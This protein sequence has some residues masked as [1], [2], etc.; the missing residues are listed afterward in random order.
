VRT[1]EARTVPA[2]FV[3]N[4]LLDGPV[5]AGGDLPGSLRQAVF[6]ANAL[7]GPDVIDLT[8]VPGTIVLAAGELGVTDAVA[9]QGPGAAKLTLDGAGLSRLFNISDGKAASIAVSLS[10]LT[11]TGGSVADDDGGAILCA[12]ESLTL[13]GMVVAGNKLTGFFGRGGG[14]AMAADFQGGSLTVT[15]STIADNDAAI[16]QGGGIF[17]NFP[18]SAGNQL[19]LTNSTISGNIAGRR[20]GGIYFSAGTYAASSFSMRNCTVS[21]NVAYDEFGGGIMISGTTGA[22]LSIAN[23]TITGNRTLTNPGGGGLALNYGTGT[24]S[25]ESTIIS[26]NSGPSPA[27]DLYSNSNTTINSK[28]NLLG[29]IGGVINAG[30]NFVD[31]GGTI[32]GAAKLAPLANNG[33]PTRTHLLTAVSPAIDAGSNPAPALTTDQR[34]AGFARQIG[35]AVDIGAVEYNP[36]LPAALATTTN[37]TAAGGTTYTFTV[38]YTDDVGINVSTIGNGD[39][40]VTG[41]NGFDAAATFISIDS[42][43]NGTPRVATYSITTP[44]GA[45]DFSD[46]GTYSI[47][48]QPNQV[49]DV[50]GTAI[51]TDVVGTFAVAIARSLV[52]TSAADSG[53]GSLRE[54]IELANQNAFVADTITFDTVA[55]GTNLIQLTSNT[56]LLVTDAVTISA[57]SPVTIDG[58][59]QSRIMTVDGPGSIAVTLSGLI[60]VNGFVED[61]PGGAVAFANEALTLVNCTFVNN[62]TGDGNTIQGGAG[63]AVGGFGFFTGSLLVDGCTFDGN[64]TGAGSPFN[65]GGAISTGGFVSNYDVVIRN[66]T[67]VNNKSLINSGGALSFNGGSLLVENSTFS[68]NTAGTGGGAIAGGGYMNAGGMTIRNTTIS[69]NKSFSSGGGLFLSFLS[70]DANLVNCTVVDNV[71]ADPNGQFAGGGI[72]WEG[73]FGGV[74]NLTNTVVAR[75]VSIKAA[76]IFSSQSV[77]ANTSFIGIANGLTLV[78]SGNITG[79]TFSP[80][81]PFLAPLANNGGPTATH[82]PYSG[83]PL[84]DAGPATS[85]LTNDQ[86]GAGFPRVRNGK[87]DIG[88]VEVDPNIPSAVTSLAK[89]TTAG[90]TVYTFT[91]TYADD[92]AINVSTLDNNDVRVTGPNGFDVFATFK[93]VTPGGNGTPRVATYEFTPPGG[94]WDG[95]D[96]GFYNVA[97]DTNQVADTSGNFVQ[98]HVIGTF[99]CGIPLNL[100]VTNANDTGPGSLRAAIEFANS[101]INVT[102]T[103][104]FDPGFFATPR[105]ITLT[106]GELLVADQVIIANATGAANVTLMGVNSRIMTVDGPFTGAAVTISGLTLTKGTGQGTGQFSAAV[107]GGAILNQ[108]EA[109][110][111]TDCVFTGNSALDNSNY[112]L[113]AGG[114]IYLAS[115]LGSLTIVDSTLTGNVSQFGGGAIAAFYDSSITITRCTISGNATVGN[116]GSG[117]GVLLNNG[118]SLVI[119]SSSIV[120]NRA[121]AT[122]TSGGGGVSVGG[123]GTGT[124]TNST[125][126][127]NVADGSGG[128]VNNSFGFDLTIR[129]S[130]ITGNAA[131]YLGGGIAGVGYYG[132]VTL[133][134]TIV[135]GNRNVVTPDLATTNPAFTITANNSLIGAAD[136]AP[137]TGAANKTGTKAAPLDPLLGPLTTNGGPTLSFAPRPGSPAIDAGTNPAGLTFDQR[138][139][140]F[141]RVLG[142]AADIGA[143]EVNPVLPVATGSFA[144]VVAA[145]GTNYTLKINFSDDTAINVATLGTGDVRVTGPGGFNVIPLFVSVDVNTNGTPRVATYSFVAPGGAWDVNDVGNYTVSIEPNQ[146]ADVGGN[147]VAAAA[148]NALRVA[149]P[150]TLVVTNDLDAGPGS[151][152][153]AIEQANAAVGVSDVITFDPA[154]FNTPRTITLNGGQLVINDP[155]TITGP[156]A[157]LVTVDAA[158]L[159]R[160]LSIDLGAAEWGQ[161]V[162]LSGLTLANGYTGDGQGAGI[163]NESAALVLDSCVVSGCTNDF[164]SGGAIVLNSIYSPLT[165]INTTITENSAFQGAGIYVFGGIPSIPESLLVTIQNSTISKN[166]T[167]FGGGAGIFIEA[168]GAV[169]IQNSTLAENVA[170]G[171]G[172]GVYVNAGGRLTVEGSTFTGNASKSLFQGGGAL[173]F[174]GDAVGSITNSTISG[175]TA[176]ESAG[177]ILAFYFDGTLDI[178]NTTIAFNTAVSTGGGITFF[179]GSGQLSLASTIVAKNTANVAPDLESGSP[180]QAFTVNNSL[181]GATDGAT[182]TGSNNI[183]GTIVSP[184]DPLLD[185]TLANNGGPTQT[186]KLLVGSPAINTGSNPAGLLFDQRGTGFARVS[187]GGVDMGAFEIQS[188]ASP[189][190]VTSVV[191]N[192]GGAQRSMVTSLKVTFSEAVTFPN[193]IAAAFQLERV[194]QPSGGPSAGAPLGLVNISAVQ[195]GNTV[196]ITFLGG[197]AVPIDLAGSLIDGAYRLTIVAANV[198][199]AG[200]ALDGNGNGIGGDDF[201]TPAAGAGRLFRLF[202]DNDGD[203]DVDAQD[204]GAFRA[205]FGGGSNL[206]FDFDG[207]GDVDAADF[208]QFRARFGSGV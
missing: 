193:G 85:P 183:T 112:T 147:F 170:D 195:A 143:V 58:L 77:T 34:G 8:G 16:G 66:S 204:F 59:V 104:S 13:D 201:Q 107:S 207:D 48:L 115:G 134:S 203:A 87:V 161:T 35:A 24:I 49:T 98:G 148:V 133:V 70:V 67:F 23:S 169:V 136:T 26:D 131:R 188:A 52:V 42:P 9:I 102:D 6:D 92:V 19:T 28:N 138:G 88:A 86:R 96:V 121:T 75:N 7:A 205:A 54:A 33:G 117:G 10:G 177:G 154:F 174:T 36:A 60:F 109:L 123:F 155:V 151:L 64:Q 43:T 159:Y 32:I 29:G 122:G 200:G 172:G 125:I 165:L 191:V 111:V 12:N 179:G 113:P 142:A 1:L 132:S 114:A 56:E 185:A 196:T 4:N 3:V 145:G 30:T 78:G 40:R 39:I 93:G 57:G 164:F 47:L 103:I 156:G 95:A 82:L 192:T 51:A 68:N 139:T 135:A 144:P 97:V 73:V 83:S 176:D 21:G 171:N 153:D 20:G 120:G 187:G 118:G 128:G 140:G 22:A 126:A 160:I 2:T 168:G 150:R 106:S 72:A 80:A 14:I 74:L 116:G 146:V 129:N 53:P 180:T 110:T 46:N 41:P 206:A 194:G 158:G 202:G 18:S 162:K 141:A 45:W 62:A 186:H 50:G 37:I 11:L 79:T 184:A 99:Q 27:A 100:V 17:F 71:N 137:I 175:N 149:I 81:N 157:G 105:T 25:I 94:A 90:G 101:N 167:A 69:G 198:Q 119:D 178:R 108:D 152:R 91:V 31:Q 163:V 197:G 38:T 208:G 61:G 63:G 89:V 44:G 15:N 76:D 130:T 65:R 5:N 173:F 199:G 55:M 84:V 182:I 127:N 190:T 124:I 181:V 189:P 166:T